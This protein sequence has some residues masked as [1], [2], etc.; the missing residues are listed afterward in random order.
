MKKQ[1]QYE[2]DY[3]DDE[4]LEVDNCCV[5]RYGSDGEAV[6]NYGNCLCMSGWIISLCVIILGGGVMLAVYLQGTASLERGAQ[7][8]WDESKQQ[9]VM[10]FPTRA[11][12]MLWNKHQQW[13]ADV[14]FVTLS[15]LLPFLLLCMLGCILNCFAA[16]GRVATAAADNGYEYDRRDR[17]RDIEYGDDDEGSYYT[18]EE[19]E[20]YTDED[21][22]YEEEAREEEGR[23][24]LQRQ[25]QAQLRQQQQQQLRAR[26]AQALAQARLRTAQ[27]QQV[28][29]VQPQQ[30]TYIGRN[31]NNS[32]IFVVG[33]G[34]QAQQQ[35]YQR[36]Q[37]LNGAQYEYQ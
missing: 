35:A 24:L 13:I 36:M 21:E 12:E 6:D 22:Y 5:L 20:E 1:Q 14:H 37:A 33:A 19:E 3:Y 15:A 4:V 11:A 10:N 27:Q 7:K 8:Y 9:V 32:K 31:A 30:K 29:R 16:D 26:Q 25:R 2:E 18:D 34:P 28:Q 23:S 17:D